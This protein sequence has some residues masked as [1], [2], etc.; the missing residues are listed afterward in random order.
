LSE[1]PNKEEI[2]DTRLTVRRIVVSGLLAAITM[3]LGATRLG[4]VPVPTAAGHA[5][6][7]HIP[8]VLGGIL[9]GWLVGGIVGLIFGIFSFINAQVPLFR[10]PLVAIVP[11]IFIGITA[12]LTYLA[13]RRWNVVVASA[14]ATVV[15]TLTNTI[16]VLGMAVVRGYMPPLVAAGVALTHGIPEVVVAVIIVT[17]V[18]AAALGWRGIYAGRR[19]ANL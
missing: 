18:T 3:L 6:I 11:R 12:A 2:M 1:Q 10:D 5:T 16:L 7:M 15:G 17:A 4:F 9:E 14:V 8:A 13:L 19:K